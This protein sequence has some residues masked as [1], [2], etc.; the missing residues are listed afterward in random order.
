[1]RI[2]EYGLENILSHFVVK[3]LIVQQKIS[4]YSWWCHDS[5]LGHFLSF[6]Y[7]PIKMSWNWLNITSLFDLNG[8]L[9]TPFI[10]SKET[11]VDEDDHEFMIMI[12][13]TM[14]RFQGI[15]TSGSNRY[16]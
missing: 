9:V 7:N 2:S 1:M 5:V 6:C 11:D 10:I 16:L 3:L 14:Q 15:C 13:G 12:P 8:F 4:K